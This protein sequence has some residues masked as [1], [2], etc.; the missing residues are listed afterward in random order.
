MSYYVQ[1]KYDECWLMP[2]F[3]NLLVQR[4]EE[5]EM[6][7]EEKG[8]SSRETSMPTSF[9]FPTIQFTRV[10][11][12]LRYFH[13][14]S[15]GAIRS[16]FD[17]STRLWRRSCDISLNRLHDKKDLQIPPSS[18]FAV[19]PALFTQTFISFFNLSTS[20]GV[21]RKHTRLHR[22]RPGCL[23]STLSFYCAWTAAKFERC[24]EKKH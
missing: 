4:Q 8:K 5:R 2:G 20:P 23:T 11:L 24:L 7:R 12:H 3:S 22:K 6:L 16:I 17:I 13:S 1:L 21:Q 19:T 15:R 14:N 10:H 9:V 18:D